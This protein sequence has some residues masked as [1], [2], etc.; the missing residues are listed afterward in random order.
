MLHQFLLGMTNSKL[1]W[2]PHYFSSLLILRTLSN[3]QRDPNFWSGCL[4][5][6]AYIYSAGY[7]LF[8]L[9]YGFWECLLIDDL[10]PRC[11]YYFFYLFIYFCWCWGFLLLDGLTPN[12]YFRSLALILIAKFGTNTLLYFVCVFTGFGGL[13]LLV[14]QNLRFLHN[15]VANISAYQEYTQIPDKTHLLMSS[16][17]LVLLW[18]T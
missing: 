1:C 7:S 18:K 6:V 13:P 12:I 16:A 3:W 5:H 10:A 15:L 11:F 17:I 14:A 2:L 9:F 8:F 4:I